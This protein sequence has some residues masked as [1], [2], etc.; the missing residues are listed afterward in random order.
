MP[1]LEEA[2]FCL[3]FMEWKFGYRRIKSETVT[4]HLAI[5][6]SFCV[7]GG[8]SDFRLKKVVILIHFLLFTLVFQGFLKFEGLFECDTS[9]IQKY[10]WQNRQEQG[11]LVSF[12][13]FLNIPLFNTRLSFSSSAALHN[14]LPKKNNRKIQKKYV[15]FSLSKIN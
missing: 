12:H 15:F 8:I 5:H 14:L 1:Y 10:D 2:R 9:R 3:L 13:L 7:V 4:G 11:F 6:F